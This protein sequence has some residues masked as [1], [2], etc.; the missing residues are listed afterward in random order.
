M[1][2]FIHI[3]ALAMMIVLAPASNA[4]QTGTLKRGD[5]V[6]IDLKTPVEDSTSVSS[7]YVVSDDGTIKMPYLSQPISAAGLN[8]ESLARKIEAAYREGKIYTAPTL[9]AMLNTT[10]MAS[11]VFTVSGEVRTPG[12][13]A[14]REG[15]D[16]VTAISKAGGFGDFAKTKAVKVIRGNKATIYDMR[17]IK[18]D[19]SNN[20]LIKDGDTI[21]VPQ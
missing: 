12:E 18:T 7:K 1:K 5:V 6:I 3:L 11:H 10:D 21:I 20:P 15:T 4:Q 14:L 16:L 2:S 19:G 8:S 13:F 9:T 17:S